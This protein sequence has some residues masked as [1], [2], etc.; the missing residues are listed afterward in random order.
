MKLGS[1]DFAIIGAGGTGLAAAMYG[2][3]LGLR[4]VV[5]GASHGSELPI[6]GVIT[7][8]DIVENYPGF[9]RTSGVFL[10]RQLEE[11]ARAYESVTIKQEKV[12]HIGKEKKKFSIITEK[13]SYDAKT[14]LFATGAKLRTLEI[15]GIKKFE[16]KGVSYCALCDAPLYKG[17]VVA[18][19]GGGDGA[20]KEALLL[21]NF[22]NKVYIIYRGEK[23]RPE[24]ANLKKI[25]KNKK[26]EV[27][28][29]TNVIEVK[30]DKFVKGVLLDKSYNGKKEIGLDGVFIAIGH[31]PLSD[32]AKHIGVKVNDKGEIP[33]NHKTSETNV[34]GVFAAGDIT[35]KNFKQLITGVGEGV[36]AAYSAYEF[37]K[38]N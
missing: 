38:S 16:G 8:T 34:P 27:I 6:G 28:N 5:F 25:E 26:I 7:T 1:Y 15:P 14:I 29:K 11:H 3:R 24:H 31:V 35:D 22:A 30:G 19:V 2:G 20:A 33:I 23:I 37:L 4:T 10:S 13:G 32:L 36:T 18:V 21:S 17:K 12:L 9:I